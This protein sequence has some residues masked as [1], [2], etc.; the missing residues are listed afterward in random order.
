MSDNNLGQLI[1]SLKTEAIEAAEKE[2]ASILKAAEEQAQQTIDNANRKKEEILSDAKEKADDILEK[3]KSALQRA[4]R[5]FNIS[6]RNDVIN[7]FQAVF[8]KEIRKE[9]SPGLIKNAISKVI[10]NVGSDAE[11]KFS[12]EAME[13][14]VS[15]IHSQVQSSEDLPSLIQDD[16]LLKGFSITKTSQGWTYTVSPE[17]VAESLRSHLSSNWIETLKDTE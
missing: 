8:E 12:P 5:D 11:I 13:E 16:S 9:F 1:S 10:E 15:Y 2:S 6:V 3:G 4:A 7:I 14:M 17:G